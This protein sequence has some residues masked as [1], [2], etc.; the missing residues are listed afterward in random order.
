MEQAIRKLTTSGLYSKVLVLPRK[1]L[2]A[3]RWREDQKLEVTLDEEK[4]QMIIKDAK[5]KKR[6]K[7]KKK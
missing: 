4:K 1:F 5:T 7:R 6:R 2:R 3:L